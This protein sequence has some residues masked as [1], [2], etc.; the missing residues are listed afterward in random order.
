MAQFEHSPGDRSGSRD[1]RS[2]NTGSRDRNDSNRRAQ[3]RQQ[4]QRAAAQKAAADK[5][6]ADFQRSQAAARQA[7]GQQDAGMMERNQARA[8]QFAKYGS[9]VGG[10]GGGIMGG[11][12]GGLAGKG[13]G[14][15][16]GRGIAGQ[17][18]ETFGG[19]NP[20]SL[21]AGYQGGSAGQP[22]NRRVGMG[23]NNDRSGG[24]SFTGATGIG[25]QFGGGQQGGYQG[26][27]MQG[28]ALSPWQQAGANALGQQQALLGMGGQAA[29][30][31][32][33]EAFGNSPG[34]Q[35]LRD[36]QQ[37]ALMRN[38]AAMGGLG[39][40]NVRTAL[41]E[42][43][44]G[45]AAQDYNNQFNRL[46]QL[47]GQG[48]QATTA[49]L[50]EN[51]RNRLNEQQLNQMNQQRKAGKTEGILNLVGQFEEPLGDMFSNIGDSVSDWIGW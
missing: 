10:I 50:D 17:F 2:S 45:N 12:V 33:F 51:F 20:Q 7:S 13:A 24:G 18:N 44:A 40:G 19:P 8:D 35:F 30:D 3:E 46:G 34:Q 9:A 26:G 21:T 16:A 31:Q 25:G 15:L 6:A 47:S 11:G 49:G 1:E 23:G 48:F 43:A 38:S 4:A 32:A 22:T 36:R 5:R 42:Q 14:S 27:Q 39:G 37:K 29:Q 41:Q 28:G